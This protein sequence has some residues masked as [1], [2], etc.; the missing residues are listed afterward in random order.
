MCPKCSRARGSIS[1]DTFCEGCTK[2]LPTQKFSTELREA[3]KTNTCCRFL[4]LQC[5]GQ[6]RATE[7]LFCTPCGR[8]W[9]ISAFDDDELREE[10]TEVNAD[11]ARPRR[12][13]RCKAMAAGNPK[14]TGEH[15][16]HRCAVTKPWKDY[17]PIV[18]KLR[19]CG[20]TSRGASSTRKLVCEACQ[21][22]KCAGAHCLGG[23]PRSV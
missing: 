23:N 4:C 13:L 21:Y 5:A 8:A 22:P 6:P 10:S 2:L 9:L 3:W 17:S 11:V 20:G 12:C 16:C 15:R 1:P 18:L 7:E 14:L 19:L